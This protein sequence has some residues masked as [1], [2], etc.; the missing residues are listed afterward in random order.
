MKGYIH[1][2]DLHSSSCSFH[3]VPYRTHLLC[4]GIAWQ[5]CAELNASIASAPLISSRPSRVAIAASSSGRRS[6]LGTTQ[7]CVPT[8]RITSCGTIAEEPPL[9]SVSVKRSGGE[10]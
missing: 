10:N 3:F 5:M 4:D 9:G 6:V 7:S 1:R 8:I 2:F